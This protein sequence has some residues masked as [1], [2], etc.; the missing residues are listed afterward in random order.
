MKEN[1]ITWLHVMRLKKMLSKSFELKNTS[2]QLEQ[3]DTKLFS[4]INEK[5]ILHSHLRPYIINFLKVLTQN[6]SEEDLYNFLQNM[7]TLKTNF[8]NFTIYNMLSHRSVHGFYS[9]EDNTISLSKRNYHLTIYHEL[10]H[11]ASTVI[12]KDAS[13]LYTGFLQIQDNDE[14]IGNGLNEGYTQYL[15]ERYFS[16]KPILKCYSYETRI[17]SIIEQIIGSSK[18]QSFYF[19][20]NLSG[21]VDSL[22]NY[23]SKDE[24]DKFITT[25]DDISNYISCGLLKAKSKDAIL[26]NSFIDINNFLI[27]TSLKQKILE[28]NEHRIIIE[29]L[30]HKIDPVLCLLPQAVVYKY[31]EYK[32]Y[33]TDLLEKNLSIVLKDYR[34]EHD[35]VLIK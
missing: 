5:D 14:K 24:I 11:M 27:Q 29:H 33:D 3:H 23:S 2:E 12:E 15:T 26:K 34:L 28:S 18:M 17:A 8:K 35:K 16:D 6:I 10:F 19:H 31:K 13:T 20:G 32:A 7:K 9:Y 1:M 4:D 21:V 30:I 22:K 25:L